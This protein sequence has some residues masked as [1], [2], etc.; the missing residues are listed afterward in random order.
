MGEE[1]LTY[2]KSGY[3]FSSFG[4]SEIPIIF[5][6]GDTIG[7]LWGNSS[8]DIHYTYNGK[9]RG[10]LK[11]NDK[12]IHSYVYTGIVPTIDIGIGTEISVN[13]GREPFVF[14]M[15]SYCKLYGVTCITSLHAASV[16]EEFWRKTIKP[17]VTARFPMVLEKTEMIGFKN[18]IGISLRQHVDTSLLLKVKMQH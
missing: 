17:E 14:D 9:I 11:I 6:P 10:K 16:S 5:Q 12:D 13:F 3:A 2:V 18:G 8:T 15:N 4:M 7:M 1:W